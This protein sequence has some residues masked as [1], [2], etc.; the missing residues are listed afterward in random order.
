MRNLPRLANRSIPGNRIARPIALAANFVKEFQP[1][2]FR[3]L[4]P[5]RLEPAQDPEERC[6]TPYFE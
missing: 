5:M 1:T 3:G 6:A 2:Q 4:T